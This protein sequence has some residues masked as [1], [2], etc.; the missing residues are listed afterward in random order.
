MDAAELTTEG[1]LGQGD[2]GRASGRECALAL[3]DGPQPPTAIIAS[4]DLMA[5]ATLEVARGRG[6]MVPGDLS[7]ISFDDTPIA[8][9]VQPPLTAIVQPIA[10]VVEQAVELIVR[11][12]QGHALPTEALAIPCSLAVRGSTGEVHSRISTTRALAKS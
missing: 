10:E 12:E 8:R 7:L 6:M 5:L 1:L 9:S 4:S 3:L 2:F 11:A